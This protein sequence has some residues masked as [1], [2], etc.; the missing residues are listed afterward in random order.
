MMIIRFLLIGVVAISVGVGCTHSLRVSPIG[1]AKYQ[2]ESKMANVKEEKI[3]IVK[4]KTSD[5][6]LRRM[7]NSFI[8]SFSGAYQGKLVKEYDRGSKAE[9]VNKIIEIGL[10]EMKYGYNH[11]K[12]FFIQWPGF[13][14][15][16]PAWNGL[17][18]HITIKGYVKIYNAKDNKLLKESEI[19]DYYIVNYTEFGRGTVS[20]LGGWFAFSIPSFIGAF[21]PSEWDEGMKSDAN[22]RLENYFGKSLSAKVIKEL[23]GL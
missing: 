15:F 10:T 19:N 14:I 9:A 17:S 23:N 20:T 21:V 16:M 3:G 22:T 5:A 13:L 2:Y 11:P 6:D 4:A 8:L 7:F 1:D 12:S 18:Y